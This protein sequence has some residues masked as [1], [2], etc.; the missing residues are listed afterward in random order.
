MKK[1]DQLKV[2]EVARINAGRWRGA[3]GVVVAMSED[4]A[5]ARVKVE[6]IYDGEQVDFADW[7]KVGALGRNHG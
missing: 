4:G 6:G 1:G 5:Q 2:G 3:V 7:F